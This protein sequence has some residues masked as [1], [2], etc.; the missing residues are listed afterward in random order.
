MVN[1][2]FGLVKSILNAVDYEV[3]CIMVVL[4]IALV[5]FGGL[6]KLIHG[7]AIVELPRLLSALRQLKL[8]DVKSCGFVIR[9]FPEES[10]AVFGDP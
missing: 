3:D 5:Y 6:M 9:F 4:P 10:L 1:C 7:Q 8:I 2:V